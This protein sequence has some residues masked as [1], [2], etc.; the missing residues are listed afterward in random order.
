MAKKFTVQIED[1]CHEDWNRMTPQGV[2]RHC[3]AC[4]KVVVDFSNK[5]D[6]YIAN[7]LKKHNNV[8]GRFKGT[9]LNRPIDLA[10]RR[11]SLI[12][13]LAAS[14]M[15]PLA[16][17]AT[18][19]AYSQG[20]VKAFERNT[21]YQSLDIG[22]KQLMPYK[23]IKGVLKDTA[24]NPLAGVRVR[25]NESN[26]QIQTDI[27]GTYRLK[28]R[29]GN[30]LNFSYMGFLTEEF[31]VNAVQDVYDFVLEKDP[32]MLPEVVVSAEP[33]RRICT[34]VAGNITSVESEEWSEE[35]TS[36]VDKIEETGVVVYE[37]ISFDEIIEIKEDKADSLQQDSMAVRKLTGVVSDYVGPLPYVNVI[38]KGTTVGTHTDFDGLY[39]IDVKPGQ[40]LIFSFVGFETK[41]VLIRPEDQEKNVT[42]ED[43]WGEEEVF[44]TGIIAVKDTQ[45]THSTEYRS[46]YNPS[47][48]YSPDP[49][50]E[51]R[52]KAYA[53]TV[54]FKRL[55]KEKKKA[56]R[57]S[58]RKKRR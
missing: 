32:Y 27:N 53:N 50:K 40:T 52:K 31:T 22:S 2:G 45:P 19:S 10:Q 35:E 5:S 20:E 9:Q 36:V 21:N 38:I 3:D 24:G 37:E 11:Y 42:L 7:Y 13:P 33:L 23:D 28:V 4:E 1:P 39:E 51:A 47:L 48:N 29:I 44:F 6:A 25:V 49:E 12:P 43:T 18:T 54:E 14:F 56:E 46:A 17:L 8:C 58:S 55:Q 34:V 26:D 15:L 41:E 57:K 30:T 16:M